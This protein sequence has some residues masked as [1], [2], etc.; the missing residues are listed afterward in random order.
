MCGRV[1]VCACGLRRSNMYQKWPRERKVERLRCGGRKTLFV[2]KPFSEQVTYLPPLSIPPSSINSS[3][4]YQFL[5]LPPVTAVPFL[6]TFLSFFLP[7]IKLLSHPPFFLPPFL[8]FCPLIHLPA[9]L[10]SLISP[11]FHP[12][13][14]P[15]SFLTIIHP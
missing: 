11:S 5:L 4:L 6:P 8:Y 12:P 2:Y 7:P 13:S 10:P 14:F 1:C 9:F 15:P 3:L